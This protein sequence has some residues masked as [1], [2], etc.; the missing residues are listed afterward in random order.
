MN[1]FHHNY[2]FLWAHSHWKKI[3]PY[4]AELY[5]RPCAVY[6]SMCGYYKILNLCFFYIYPS[7]VQNFYFRETLKPNYWMWV[8]I[9]MWS[10]WYCMAFCVCPAN[11]IYIETWAQCQF[12]CVH[13]GQMFFNMQVPFT[14]QT[15]FFFTE[16]TV[17]LLLE[18]S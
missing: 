12:F 15:G 16:E 11:K 13:L 14:E 9:V 17:V 7:L 6:C 4:L 3:S 8:C 18:C 5:P 2:R 10:W 1:N